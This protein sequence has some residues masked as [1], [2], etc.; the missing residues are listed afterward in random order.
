MLPKPSHRDRLVEKMLTKVLHLL[1]DFDY[2]HAAPLGL[3]SNLLEKREDPARRDDLLLALGQRRKG[4]L[5]ARFLI[6]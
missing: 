3:I 6:P 1:F 4:D 5:P 2:S